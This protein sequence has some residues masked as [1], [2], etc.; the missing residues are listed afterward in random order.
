[1]VYHNLCG[2]TMRMA[3]VICLCLE[4]LIA[5]TRESVMAAVGRQKPDRQGVRNMSCD[6]FWKIVICEDASSDLLCIL[7][8]HSDTSELCDI[9]CALKTI[10]ECFVNKVFECFYCLFTIYSSSFRRPLAIIS[11]RSWSDQF[12]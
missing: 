6:Y 12:M 10:R 9:I 5:S 7:I 8:K 4:Q 11:S 3:A 2:I 1:M